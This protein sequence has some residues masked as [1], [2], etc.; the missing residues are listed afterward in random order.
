MFGNHILEQL[1]LTVSGTFAVAHVAQEGLQDL[2]VA[3]A[4]HAFRIAA[5]TVTDELHRPVLYVRAPS[6]ARL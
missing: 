1:G 2:L 4:L 3:L 6:E 5:G